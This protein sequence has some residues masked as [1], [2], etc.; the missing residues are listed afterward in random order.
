MVNLVLV[1]ILGLFAGS[2]ITLYININEFFRSMID[3]PQPCNGPLYSKWK[4]KEYLAKI[5]EEVGEVETALAAYRMRPNK[6]NY[7]WLM[8]ECTD[9]KTITTSF[10]AFLGA[11]EFTRSHYQ[12]IVNETNRYRDDGRR[13]K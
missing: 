6:A 8:L 9:V 4:D 13:V 10:Q 2:I 11:D 3:T 7:D 5:Y 12:H 1:F